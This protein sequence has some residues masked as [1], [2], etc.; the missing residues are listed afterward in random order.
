MRLT[1]KKLECYW[2]VD[3]T[4]IIFIKIQLNKV[5]L[6]KFVACY[7]VFSVLFNYWDNAY[8]VKYNSVHLQVRYTQLLLFIIRNPFDRTIW[9]LRWLEGKIAIVK[10][11]FCNLVVSCEKV[12]MVFFPLSSPVINMLFLGDPEF[13]LCMSS[14]AHCD[15]YNWLLLIDWINKLVLK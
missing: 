4:L 2:A 9:I 1:C 6:F 13:I 14:F 10:W 15:V 5:L 11:K 3:L 8:N 12:L 7:R